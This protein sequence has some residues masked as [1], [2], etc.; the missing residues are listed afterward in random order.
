MHMWMETS[1]FSR[2]EEEMGSQEKEV[3]IIHDFF[4]TRDWVG[5][6]LEV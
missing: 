1:Y 5:E 2:R 4:K 6:E 3:V